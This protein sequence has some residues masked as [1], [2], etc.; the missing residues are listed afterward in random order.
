MNLKLHIH[1]FNFF[2]FINNML[3]YKVILHVSVFLIL[4]YVL[5]YNRMFMKMSL[6][7]T[8]DDE[9]RSDRVHGLSSS[10]SEIL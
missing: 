1:F 6:L 5:L 4:Y 7:I 2:Y 3:H 10:V 9:F 8:R